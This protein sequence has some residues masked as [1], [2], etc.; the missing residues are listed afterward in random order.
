MIPQP[1]FPLLL[2]GVVLASIATGCKK[3]VPAPPPPPAPKAELRQ[4]T[5]N[6]PVI[7]VFTAEPDMIDPGDSAELRWAVSDAVEVSIDEGIGAVTSKGSQRITPSASMT[8]TLQAKGPGGSASATT[9]IRVRI[10]HLPSR[11]APRP[12]VTL[13][14]RV[15]REVEDAF[16]N[17]DESVLREDALAALTRNATAFK[18]ILGEIPIGLI[19]IEGHCDE[20]GSAEYNL[21]L[22]DRRAT[23]ARAYLY[24]LGVPEERLNIVSYGKEKPQCHESAE[25]CWQQNRRVHFRP[26]DE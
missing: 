7:H 24:Q 25:S 16:F 23:A 20:R 19:V 14:E 12:T 17:F 4:P 9:S 21:G 15:A 3:K 8:Y 5:P 2:L 6:R 22:G 13:T 11:P 18:S 10:A 26:A 1:Q